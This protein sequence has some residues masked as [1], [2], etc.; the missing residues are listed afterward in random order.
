[1]SA[2]LLWHIARYAAHGR[3]NL[4]HTEDGQNIWPKHVEIVYNRYKITVQLVGS[5]ICLF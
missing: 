4:S 3:P 5:E 2:N 1:M